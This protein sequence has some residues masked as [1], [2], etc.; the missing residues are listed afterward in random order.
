LSLK[1][2]ISR[3]PGVQTA[4]DVRRLLAAERTRDYELRWPLGHYYSPIPSLS[5]VRKHEAAIWHTRQSLAGIDLRDADQLTLVR[6]F[7]DFYGEFTFPDLKTSG[8]R[9]HLSNRFFEHS[10]GVMLYSMMRHLKPSRVVE[11]GCGFS[12]ALML[13]VNDRFLGGAT[14]FTFI[15]PD[16]A[17][18]DVLLT[19]GDRREVTLA[20]ARVQDADRSHF[21]RLGAGDIL[22]ID[23]S[24]VAKVGSDVNYLFFEVLPTLRPGVVVHV[25][26]IGWPFECPKEW[27]YKGHAENE[28]YLLRAFLTCNP[29]YRILLFNA[30]LS[31]FH[32]A[33]VSRLLPLW[34]TSVGGS[35]WLE[36]VA[37]P[38]EQPASVS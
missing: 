38:G 8:F 15:E 4:L 11:V 34:G 1:H 21:D 19:P 10:D 7:R 16:P 14:R 20:A 24:H 13:D 17:R 23:S 25:H 12:S 26:D 3:I 2:W 6:R 35:I 36:R 9:Y 37:A 32:G 18:L 33:E 30:Y 27:V 5:D 22:F 28:C 29:S 31:T